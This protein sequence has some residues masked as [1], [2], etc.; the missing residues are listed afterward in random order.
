MGLCTATEVCPLRRDP[1]GRNPFHSRSD[2]LFMCCRQAGTAATGYRQTGDIL[3][4]RRQYDD[5]QGQDQDP[6]EN[7]DGNDR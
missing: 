1:G 6:H 4:I 7:I 3:E 5:Q 2:R